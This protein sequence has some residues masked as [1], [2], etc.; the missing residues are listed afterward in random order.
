MTAKE[1]SRLVECFGGNASAF[2]VVVQ[3][4]RAAFEVS[5]NG[6]GIAYDLKDDEVAWLLAAYAGSD[7][8]AQ[9]ANRFAR[10][11]NLWSDEQTNAQFITQ[12]QLIVRGDITGISEVRIGRNRDRAVILYDDGKTVYYHPRPEPEFPDSAGFVS[13]G[14]LSGAMLRA[15]ADAIAD[16]ESG[17]FIG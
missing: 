10:I 16:H 7:V 1:L 5:T 14:V 11:I 17:E 3:K 2:G 6:R 9:S 13:E 8:A 12:F 4:L 15:L